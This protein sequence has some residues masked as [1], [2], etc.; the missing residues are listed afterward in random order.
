MCG[1]VDTNGT[2][3][4]DKLAKD[5]TKHLPP[6]ARPVFL[7]VLTGMDMTGGLFIYDTLEHRDMAC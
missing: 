4:L 7:R 6:Y 1:I 2:L 3:D 5:L